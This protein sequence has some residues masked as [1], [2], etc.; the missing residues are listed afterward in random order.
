[1]RS[2]FAANL[3]TTHENLIAEPILPSCFLTVVIPVRN[4]AVHLSKTLQN[5]SAQID[6]QNRPLDFRQFEIIFLVNN[7]TDD[8]A[9]IIRCWRV[10]NPLLSVHLAERNLPAEHSNIGFVRRWL[11][12]EAYLRLCGNGFKDGIIATTDG[13]TEIAR[14]WIA[15]TCAE[16]KSGAEAVGGR[17]F[18]A[19]RD[20]QK[21]NARARAFHLRDTGYRLMTAEIEARLDYLAHDP[22]PRHHQ[23]FNGSF[24]VTTRAFEKAGGIPPVSFLEDVA[25]Y[26][27][28]LRVDARFRHSPAVRA[29][30]SARLVGRAEFGLSTQINEWTLMGK[31]GDQYL[32]ESAAT[33]E[34]RLILRKKLRGLWKSEQKNMCLSDGLK[35]LADNLL[36]SAD[37]LNN[38]LNDSPTFGRLHEKVIDEQNRNGDWHK[39][40]PR[41]PVEKAVFDLRLRLEKFRC[42]GKGFLD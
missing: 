37:F 20:L 36:I 15:T 42:G 26:H 18:I 23:H 41:E 11:M 28:L 30:T 34:R 33:I 3:Q 32:V 6:L 35:T 7:T 29:Q 14:N 2:I 19:P 12:N 31:N 16:I 39:E 1:M 8:S 22:A 17:I 38:E 40:N 4:E 9:E 10:K 25:F 5:L 13:D 27:S 21:M 24:A